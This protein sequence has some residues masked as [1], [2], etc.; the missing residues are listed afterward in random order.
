MGRWQWKQVWWREEVIENWKK[1]TSAFPYT[2]C[3]CSISHF[4]FIYLPSSGRFFWT[5]RTIHP[6]MSTFM[7]SSTRRSTSTI[8]S[9]IT[10]TYTGR[11]RRTHTIRIPTRITFVSVADRRSFSSP[12]PQSAWPRTISG[13]QSFGVAV[14]ASGTRTLH[15]T[16][17]VMTDWTN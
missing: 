16:C 14:P 5:N 11:R 8:K 12:I 3:T 7:L 13:V 9:I 10:G 2:R 15:P 6:T 1:S 17:T 4:V